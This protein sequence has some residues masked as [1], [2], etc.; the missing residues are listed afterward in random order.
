MQL[1][2]KIGCLS[3]VQ[4][5]SDIN[6]Q[7]A[8]GVRGGGVLLGNVGRV[9]RRISDQNWP[10]PLTISDLTCYSVRALKSHALRVRLTQTNPIFHSQA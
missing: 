7:K 9:V 10:T 6:V 3:I 2:P 1:R 4:I 8:E 5:N